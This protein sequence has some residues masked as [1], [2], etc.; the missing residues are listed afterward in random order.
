[1][2]LSAQM[3]NMLT[4]SF[5]WKLTNVPELENP[6]L[7]VFDYSPQDN[8]NLLSIAFDYSGGAKCWMSEAQVRKIGSEGP[9]PHEDYREFVCDG[10]KFYPYSIRPLPQIIFEDINEFRSACQRLYRHVV[11]SE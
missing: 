2:A 7:I 5:N 11:W 8:L 4:R 9:N 6:A 3:E 1:M 10:R